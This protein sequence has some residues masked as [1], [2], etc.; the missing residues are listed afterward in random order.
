MAA[1]STIAAS[2]TCPWPGAARFDDPAD[3]AER[4]QHPPA[5]EVADEVDRRRRALVGEPEVREHTGEGDVVDVVP[6]CLRERAVL[7]PTRH[8]PV[9]EL[10]VS[11]EARSGPTP[12]RSVTPGR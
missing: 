7:A 2:T 12:S 1:P 5:T 8:P 3:D 11:G 10:R 9:H 6:G 4:E